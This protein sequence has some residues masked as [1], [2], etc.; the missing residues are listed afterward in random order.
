VELAYNIFSG[1]DLETLD[2]SS[3]RVALLARSVLAHGL[4]CGQWTEQR[5]FPN[6]DHRAERW[7]PDQLRG[8]IKQLSVVTGILGG[9]VMTLR[10][11]ALRFVLANP[12]VS[13]AV[14]GP[15]NRVQL[16]QLVREAGSG[17]EYLAPSKVQQVRDQLAR[18]GV[19]R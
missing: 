13:S 17:P 18:M 16:D 9:E 12:T 1:L 7:T 2:V 10:A 3:G 15:R 14:L 11:A 5:T 19:S 8:R 6:A 4:L